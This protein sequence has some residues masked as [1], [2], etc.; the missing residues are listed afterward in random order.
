MG[1]NR[2]GAEEDSAPVFCPP[3]RQAGGIKRQFRKAISAKEKVLRRRSGSGPTTAAGMRG[4]LLANAHC[5]SPAHS[6]RS[7]A[8]QP[9]CAA[10]CRASDI[11][12]AQIGCKENA[13]KLKRTEKNIRNIKQRKA[14]EI[15]SATCR[16][17]PFT[18]IH[19]MPTLAAD[20]CCRSPLP[21][22]VAVFVTDTN[23]AA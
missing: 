23:I 21:T 13:E 16:P 10:G 19:N 7:C 6:R 5:K 15:A 8:P 14:T 4:R 3:D 12:N 11:R 9:A 22:P 1:T 2:T 17:K 20:V 18:M